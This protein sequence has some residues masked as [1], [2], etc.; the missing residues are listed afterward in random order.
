MSQQS[1]PANLHVRDAAPPWAGQRWYRPPYVGTNIVFFDWI[2]S[3][4]RP[5]DTVLDAGAGPGLGEEVL[6]LRGE[7]AKVCGIDIDKAVLGN[8]F[9]DEA[10]VVRGY[11]WPYPDA[12]FDLVL[13]DYVLE[14]IEDPR[15]YLAEARRVLRP[16][17]ACFFRT[18]NALHP[19]TVV[20]RWLP[21]AAWRWLIQRL[22][23]NAAAAPDPYPA[24]W[25][26]NSPSRL[27]R[28]LRASGFRRIDLRSREEPPSYLAGLGPVA[29]V[30][31]LWE[32]VANRCDVLSSVRI[33][34]YGCAR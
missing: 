1:T 17:G 25:R 10:H 31:V 12:T 7:A 18:V 24:Y 34:L 11:E 13:S 21:L 26:A 4:L 16:G 27:T 20:A 29:L 3:V 23:P 2:R 8:T 30:G 14:H 5:T 22:D 15:A 28:L 33:T 19:G 32:R 6:R 9:L